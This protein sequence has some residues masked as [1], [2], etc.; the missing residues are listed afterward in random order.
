MYLELLLRDGTSVLDLRG[1]DS[2]NV[3]NDLKYLVKTKPLSAFTQFEYK[4]LIETLVDILGI[5]FFR[6]EWTD[7]LKHNQKERRR[8]V[9]EKIK[10]YAVRFGKDYFSII[11]A[12]LRE[13]WLWFD[14]NMKD[15][16]TVVKDIIN[17][18]EYGQLS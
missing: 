8:A 5:S 12:E 11:D 2:I 10:D 6:G 15:K 14:I 1:W 13:S 18:L 3:Y 17:Y 7:R 16:E 9:L 4:A